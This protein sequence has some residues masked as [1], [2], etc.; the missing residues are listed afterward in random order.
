MNLVLPMKRP[1]PRGPLSA[2]VLETLSR[3]PS[4]PRPAG[5]ATATAAAGDALHDD[6]LQIALLLLNELHYRGIEEVDDRWEWDVDVVGLRNRLEAVLEEAVRAAAAE[7]LAAHDLT[8]DAE[9][10]AVQMTPPDAD[11]VMQVLEA[12]TAPTG[13][14]GMAAYL[15]SKASA[16]QFRELL[17]ARSLYNL[18]EADP[19]TFAIPRLNGDAKAALVEIQA[20]EYGT[21][22]PEWVHSTVFARTMEAFGLETRYGHYVDRVPAVVIASLNAM[23][24]FGLNRRLRGAVVGQLAVFE[25]TSTLPN[26][27]YAQ[28]VR[29]L[30]LGDDAALYFDEH[31]EADAVHE[32]IALRDLAGGLVRQ[33]PAVA[34]DVLLGAAAGVALDELASAH[35][36]GAWKEDRSALHPAGFPVRQPAV[37]QDGAAMAGSPG[38]PG[39]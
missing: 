18:K 38:S 9:P 22:R 26:R 13:K 15:A 20:D 27:L 6:D 16:D 36:L 7:V 5:L 23:S 24:L 14:P 39:A 30:G 19:H 21:G 28:G 25:M 4:D 1:E 29:R 2:L 32:Q 8:A 17:I 12:M 11:Q 33:E 37:P 3:D 10:W 34:G 35:L 31:V